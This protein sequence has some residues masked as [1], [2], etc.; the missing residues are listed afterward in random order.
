MFHESAPNQILDETG[1]RP[2]H[3]QP[4]TEKHSS[5][6]AP[7]QQDDNDRVSFPSAQKPLLQVARPLQFYPT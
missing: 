2:C 6:R 7:Q 1:I 4:Q 3:W 5:A